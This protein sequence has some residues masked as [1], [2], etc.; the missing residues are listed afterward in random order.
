MITKHKGVF[1][2][3]I[4]LFPGL[5]MGNV[6]RTGGSIEEIEEDSWGL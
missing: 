6:M 5:M 4:A 2:T 3:P 1:M